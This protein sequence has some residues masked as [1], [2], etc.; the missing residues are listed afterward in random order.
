MIKSVSEEQNIVVMK[1]NQ[2]LFW[3]ET[4]SYMNESCGHL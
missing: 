1:K 2:K 3:L 4:G